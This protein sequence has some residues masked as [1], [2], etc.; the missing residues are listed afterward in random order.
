MEQLDSFNTLLNEKPD[1]ALKY[2]YDNMYNKLCNKV[3]T[4]VK[5]TD[6]SEDIVQ[7]TIA[8]IW[9]KR[10]RSKFSKTLKPTFTELAEIRH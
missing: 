1:L 4:L 6:V 2:L 5:D 3:M 10:K 9:Q 7:E 8:D